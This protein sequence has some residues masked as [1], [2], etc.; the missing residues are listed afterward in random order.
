MWSTTTC[1]AKLTCF[2]LG[3]K[4]AKAAV[5]ATA[6]AGEPRRRVLRV[7]LVL[8]L[9]LGGIATIKMVCPDIPSRAACALAPE[10]GL[11][12]VRGRGT[13]RPE[14]VARRN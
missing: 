6:A 1:T 10:P 5:E 9:P 3:R 2:P 11:S 4:S 14:P 8:V 13:T 12:P 7:L